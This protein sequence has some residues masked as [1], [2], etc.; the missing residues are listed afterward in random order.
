M[1]LALQIIGVIATIVSLILSIVGIV[2]GSGATSG[3]MLLMIGIALVR[4][5]RIMYR[6]K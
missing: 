6:N 5:G 4:L 1:G 2:T 3:L